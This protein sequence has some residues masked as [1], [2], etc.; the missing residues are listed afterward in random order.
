MKTCFYMMAVLLGCALG[1]LA[2][3]MVVTGNCLPPRMVHESDAAGPNPGAAEVCVVALR[4]RLQ[5]CNNR[6]ALSYLESREAERNFWKA[7]NQERLSPADT[8]ARLNSPGLPNAVQ[9]AFSTWLDT[10]VEMDRRAAA[11]AQLERAL[12]AREPDPGDVLAGLTVSRPP[13]I[14]EREKIRTT[15]VQSILEARPVNDFIGNAGAEAATKKTEAEKNPTEVKDTADVYTNQGFSDGHNREYDKAIADFGEAI[16]LNPRLAEAYYGRGYAYGKKT[17]LDL[18]I[19]DYTEAIRLDQKLAGAYY[20]RGIAFWQKGE[21]D[22]ATSD[23][24]EAIR[25]N[26]KDA[27]AYCGRSVAYEGEG[28]YDKAISDCTEAIRLSPNY[29]S[30]YATRGVAYANKGEQDKAIADYTVAIRLDPKDD[31][32]YCGRG[33]ACARK[34]EYNK[35]IADYNHAIRLNAKDRRAYQNR[36]SAEKKKA[37]G[38]EV[39][40]T[41]RD[42]FAS[43]ETPQERLSENKVADAVPSQLRALNLPIEATDTE[44]ENLTNFNQVQFLGLTCTRITDV[45]LKHLNGLTR[46]EWL[47]LDGTKVTDAGLENLKGLDQLQELHLSDTKVTDAGL[48]HLKPLKRLQE[49]DLSKTS[50]TSAGLANLKE[51]NQL[52]KLNLSETK[53]ANAGLKHLKG[54]TKLQELNLCG[55]KVTDEGVKKLKQALPRCFIHSSRPPQTLYISVR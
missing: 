41:T 32:A 5:D 30:A 48:Q 47:S 18:A 13:G 31:V 55:T 36:A 53:I 27:Q 15:L 35:A 16:R 42:P 22:K 49:L 20:N 43:K 14:I 29:G 21:Y 33:V 51:L 17:E 4:A 39:A 46:L 45:G 12:A 19:S 54:L 50:I 37:E 52:H 8:V 1:G 28:E 34:G 6:V 40:A 7:L 11:V 10:K 3:W 2:A 9:K 26:P 44:L 38:E 25:L 24:T 23:C